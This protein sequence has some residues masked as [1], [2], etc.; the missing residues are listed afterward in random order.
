M[1]K[2]VWFSIRFSFF[3]FTEYSNFTAWIHKRLRDFEEIRTRLHEFEEIETVAS[4]EENSEDFRL[5]FI[6]EF[7]LSWCW[8]NKDRYKYQLVSNDFQIWA[9]TNFNLYT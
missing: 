1:E 9:L 7:G 2:G 5:D 8:R 4:K 3:S 6:Q